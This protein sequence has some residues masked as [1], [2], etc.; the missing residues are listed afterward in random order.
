[1]KFQA[2]IIILLVLLIVLSIAGCSDTHRE[3]EDAEIDV[4]EI[5]VSS[6]SID[7]AGKLLIDTAADKKPNNPLGSNQSP[8]LTWDAVDGAAYYTVC[9][10]DEDANWL[11]WLIL[12]LEKTEL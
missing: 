10:F 8:Q 9:M 4:P 12:D 1:M 6:G 3:F 11:H 2:V 5:T 7:E